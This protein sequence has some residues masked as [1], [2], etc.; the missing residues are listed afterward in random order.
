LYSN[1]VLLKQESQKTEWFY[2][3]LEA[4]V[5][6]IPI[7]EDLSDLFEKLEW[8]KKNDELVEKIS[9]K[10]TD[11]IKKNLMPQHVL[12]HLTFFLIEYSKRQKFIIYSP[13]YKAV[14]PPD[15]NIW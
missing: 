10:A 6:Y 1:S 14:K 5:H 8:C 3:S 13:D 7:K 2:S 4:F 9:K 15:F 11:L 12:D